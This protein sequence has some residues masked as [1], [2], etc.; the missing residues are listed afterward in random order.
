MYPTI[1]KFGPITIY[2]YGLMVALALMIGIYISR[3]EAIR[4]NTN[5]NLVYD[6]IFVYDFI[7]FV[8]ETTSF[9]QN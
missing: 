7:W 1:A 8:V 6:F 3:I 9:L 4:K 2:S 5:I